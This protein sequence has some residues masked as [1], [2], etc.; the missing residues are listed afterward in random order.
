MTSTALASSAGDMLRFSAFADC[1]L[2]SRNRLPTGTDLGASRTQCLRRCGNA[3]TAGWFI[4]DG[5]FLPLLSTDRW[6]E[7]DCFRQRSW[8]CGQQKRLQPWRPWQRSSVQ[9]WHLA[10]L[11]LRFLVFERAWPGRNRVGGLFMIA[12]VR[13]RWNNTPPENVWTDA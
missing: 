1:G 4:Y 10:G 8:S 3:A 13:V 9:Y 6:T 7:F 5:E 2:G 11:S 12:V